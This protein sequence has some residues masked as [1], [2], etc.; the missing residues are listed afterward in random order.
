MK[1]SMAT[2]LALATAA[3]AVPSPAPARRHHGVCK[4]IV[5]TNSDLVAVDLDLD[6]DLLGLI[7]LGLNLDILLGHHRKCEAA[8]CCP[9]TCEAGDRI[10]D[11]CTRY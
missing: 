6:I 10:P 9:T 5:C 8:W 11:A 1:F 2:I 4:H 7:H 3:I